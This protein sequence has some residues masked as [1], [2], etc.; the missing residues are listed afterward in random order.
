MQD[1][2][3]MSNAI[4][5]AAHLHRGLGDA[6]SLPPSGTEAVHQKG[7]ETQIRPK[8]TISTLYLTFNVVYKK[9]S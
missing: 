1:E 7:F 8:P 6:V 3:T 5:I 2:L 4:L 9:S